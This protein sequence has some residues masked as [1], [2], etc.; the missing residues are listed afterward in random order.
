MRL[1]AVLD[2]HDFDRFVE[3]LL[4]VLVDRGVRSAEVAWP[5]GW[6]WEPER[7]SRAL[8]P[9]VADRLLRGPRRGTRHRLARERFTRGPRLPAA[10]V[11]RSRTQSL[12]DFPTRRLIDLE[13]HRAVFTWVQVRLVEAGLLKGKTVAI[14][15]NTLEALCVN[16]Q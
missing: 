12:D 15:A 2:A 3:D 4:I 13:T 1:S 5:S 7:V 14:D 8:L 9:V 11:G 16:E 6:R 10:G